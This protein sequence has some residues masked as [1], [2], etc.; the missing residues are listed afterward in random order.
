MENT[1][2]DRFETAL[3]HVTAIMFAILS[4]ATW[5]LRWLVNSWM[6]KVQRMPVT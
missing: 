1:R 6:A 2:D 3:T 5:M 4:I